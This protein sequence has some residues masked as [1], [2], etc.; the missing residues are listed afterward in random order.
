MSNVNI[1]HQ[2]A[3][4]AN[5]SFAK[6]CCASVKGH[7]LPDG[8]MVANFNGGLLTSKFEVLGNSGNHR[9]RENANAVSNPGTI[10]DGNVRS[11]PRIISNHYIGSHV[12]KWLNGDV[13][14]DAS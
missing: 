2:Q 9:S 1:S 4:A 13:F 12:S 11:N 5:N 7:H 6:R 3:M 14:A 8:G 10:K